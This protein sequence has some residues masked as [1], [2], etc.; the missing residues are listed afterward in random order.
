[1][2]P[3]R[4]LRRLF[5]RFVRDNLGSADLNTYLLLTAAGCTMVGLTA[6]HLFKS[7]KTASDTFEKQVE[8][9]QRGSSP[10]GGGGGGGLG[11][12]GGGGWNIGSL[13]GLGQMAGS[14]TNGSGQISSSGNHL[15]NTGAVT[16]TSGNG[17]TTTGNGTAT[18]NNNTATTSNATAT[19]LN[20]TVNR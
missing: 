6:P 14:M 9:L 1:M 5:P 20:G 19:T 4:F 3:L 16:A 18:T 11:G 2:K 10:G 8:I 12:G 15:S 7:S 13:G 17:T